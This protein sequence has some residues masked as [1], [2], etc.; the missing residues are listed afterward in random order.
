MRMLDR[1][2]PD[3]DAAVALLTT[4]FVSGS[5]ARRAE[6]APALAAARS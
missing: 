2:E 4:I 5:S 3:V 1:G 6:R